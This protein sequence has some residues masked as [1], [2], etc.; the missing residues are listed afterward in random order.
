MPDSLLATA[1]DLP[2]PTRNERALASPPNRRPRDRGILVAHIGGPPTS[3]RTSLDRWAEPVPPNPSIHPSRASLSLRLR[4][5]KLG[6]H[7]QASRPYRFPCMIVDTWASLS[8]GTNHQQSL[9][10]QHFRRTFPGVPTHNVDV[11][12]HAS[13]SRIILAVPR[14]CASNP[15]TCR[16]ARNK[17]VY[18][19]RP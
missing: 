5:G 4:L 17:R 6:H 12:P 9:S 7:E 2:G 16:R 13:T 8:L 14:F 3:C 10:P 18:P 11:G 15:I 1:C 19:P